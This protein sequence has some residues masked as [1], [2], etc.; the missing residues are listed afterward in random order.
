MNDSQKRSRSNSSSP[1]PPS[2]AV[3]T[4]A[5]SDDA[6]LTRDEEDDKASTTIQDPTT[7]ASPSLSK[8]SNQVEENRSAKKP[9]IS[10]T[11]EEE[12]VH[13]ETPGGR[14]APTVQIDKEEEEEEEERMTEKKAGITE[15][16]G[17]EVRPF[18]GIIKQRFTDFLVRE[19]SR[20]GQV[21][22]LESLLPPEGRL[23]EE[24]RREQ[25]P[26]K[27]AEAE[28]GKAKEEEEGRGKEKE[29]TTEVVMEEEEE[30]GQVWEE[31]LDQKLR[32]FFSEGGLKELKE[33]WLQGKTP[34]LSR[35]G[36]A[37]P[38]NSE[39]SGGDAK[40]QDGAGDKGGSHNKNDNGRGKGPQR[41]ERKVLSLPLTS[42]DERTLA[43]STI[44]DAFRGKLVSQTVE[45]EQGWTGD[46]EDEEDAMMNAAK[47]EK[48]TKASRV[49]VRWGGKNDRQWRNDHGGSR[50]DSERSSQESL[51]PFIHFLLQ[52]TNRDHQ[53]AMNILAQSLGILPSKHR[54]HHKG[55]G[56]S[57]GGGLNDLGVGGTKDKRAVTVQK[58][59]LR[60]GRK[61]LEEVWKLANGIGRGG[62]RGRG[63]A[64]GG[65]GRGGG[66]TN[67]GSAAR[68]VKQALETR[69]ERGIRIGHL[70]Y[71]DHALKLGD[72]G[73][74]EF[75]I[76]LRNV[77][78]DSD[79]TIHEAIEVVRSKGFINYFGMQRFGTGS[80]PTHRF[81]VLILKRDYRGA[82]EMLM[83]YR[84]SDHGDTRAAKEAYGRGDYETA[85]QLTPW[86]NVAEKSVLNM[87]RRTNWNRA[88]WLGA[89]A[90]IPRTLRLM[91]V[92]A[93]QSYVWNRMAS[94]RIKE[95]G[96]DEAVEG[97][98]V[99]LGDEQDLDGD[100][101]EEEGEGASSSSKAVKE[102][103]LKVLSSQEARSGEYSIHQV[104]IPLPGSDV[105]FLEGSL[106]EKRYRSILAE[107]G[108]KPSDLYDSPQPEYRL[109]G[110]QRKLVQTVQ[111]G[112]G[113]EYELL[114]Y[115][116]PDVALNVS[117]EDRLLGL[118]GK[119]EEEEEEEQA[120]RQ[121]FLALR[122]VFQLPPS[123]YATML[124]REVL[125]S[126]TSSHLHREMTA[127][128]EDQAF[129]GSK[130]G[131][132]G[133]RA[134]DVNRIESSKL[135]K[136]GG[137][138]GGGGDEEGRDQGT[139]GEGETEDLVGN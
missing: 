112:G 68:T 33:L 96:R 16:M 113:I 37:P 48:P 64:G 65:R 30:E 58:V 74:N 106:H 8:G 6:T 42:K 7:S 119:R 103:K 15:Y 85:W 66:R 123:S 19:V 10:S 50:I 4:K 60:R 51:P 45:A 93:Y 125:K 39:P 131:G 73:G 102:G 137:G 132:G 130:A 80:I 75:T 108:L 79:E 36:T 81:G 1:S 21:H 84:P 83:K 86:S 129:R 20:Q 40:S 13:P 63:G 133:A 24:F 118:G 49:L 82:V 52:K 32:P 17:P 134:S 97:D 44:R 5:S 11:E 124:L 2:L 56:G 62:N 3:E 18:T 27:E 23:L 107:D 87:M 9:R 72:L 126:D 110:S 41:D 53:E 69:G 105:H 38:S 77:K 90:S 55:G 127:K 67:S 35:P 111:A 135:R 31:G 100:L 116:D 28:E 54:N 128:S 92:H 43:H 78:A 120:E 76:V 61:T 115:T 98:M 25:Q 14:P 91:Y 34:P 109:R 101:D 104:V 47:A 88:D 59:S 94:E 99:L 138:G 12:G 117:D 139:K 22:R 46:L 71:S 121:S 57:G 136:W 95:F 26:K 114:R 70:E 29:K 122:L 89:F